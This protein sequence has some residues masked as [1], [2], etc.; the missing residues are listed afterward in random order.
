MSFFDWRESYNINIKEIDEQHQAIALVINELYEHLLRN[1]TKEKT[2][3]IIHALHEY[4]NVHFKTEEKYMIENNY[5]YIEQHKAEHEKFIRDVDD[6]NNNQ[7]VF[8]NR[9]YNIKISLFL[10]KW[11]ITHILNTDKKLGTFLHKK[12][13]VF[14][15]K[16]NPLKNY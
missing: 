13:I 3:E 5:P 14:A 11:F 2:E 15:N 10:K 7:L 9:E 1:S 8:S 12:G 6:I 4:A 16:N